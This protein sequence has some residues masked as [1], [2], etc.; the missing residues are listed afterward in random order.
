MDRYFTVSQENA[1]IEV[2]NPLHLPTAMYYSSLSKAIECRYITCACVQNISYGPNNKFE[3]Q[4]E[5]QRFQC[6]TLIPSLMVP[7]ILLAL[8]VTCDLLNCCT[9]GSVRKREKYLFFSRNSLYMRRTVRLSRRTRAKG[10]N[11]YKTLLQNVLVN[12]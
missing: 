11:G 8:S 4:Y 5:I 3:V 10:F 7:V 6:N 12:S 2:I 9:C 1:A